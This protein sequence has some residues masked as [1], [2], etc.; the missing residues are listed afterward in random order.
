MRRTLAFVGAI[1]MASLVAAQ[2][3]VSGNQQPSG[4]TP[5][6]TGVLEGSRS[7]V[8]DTAKDSCE[9]IDIPDAPARAFRDYRGTVHLVSSHHILRQDLGPSLGDVKHSCDVVYNSAH[10][11]NPADYNDATWLDSF[12]SVDGKQV[13]ALGH[14]EYHGWQHRGECQSKDFTIACWYNAD[15]F[16]LSE[17]GGYH[18]KSFPA[19]ANYVIGLPYEYVVNDGPE[20]YSVDT[21]IVKAG[22]WYYAIAT[23]WNWPPNCTGEPGNECLVP[24]G[25]APIRTSNLLDPTSWRGWNGKDF[26]VSF[27]DPYLGTVQHPE[28]HVYTPVPYMFY[29]N[30][31]NIYEPTGLFVA[32]LWD[33]WNTAY[34][35]E[36]LYLSTSTDMVN[37]T[38]P[39]LVVTQADLLAKE[40]KGNWSYAYFS[41]LDPNSKDGSFSGIGDTAY[42]YY[43]RFDENDPPYVRVLFRQRIKLTLN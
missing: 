5:A 14:M 25:G 22:D 12:Y 11:A 37:W 19:P 8:F 28:E 29:V 13:V 21:G 2:S 36:G 10:D 26:S 9:L 23:D 41:L 1:F 34:G 6:I 39:S 15:T 27:V 7:V 40:P 20:G 24:F 43:V 33:P 32:T 4:E 38:T 17:D 35:P 42:V 3:P 16:H 30:A 18:F 31:L